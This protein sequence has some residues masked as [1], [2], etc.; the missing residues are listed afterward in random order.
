M[1]CFFQEFTQND[2]SEG[3]VTVIRTHDKKCGVFSWNAVNLL[4]CAVQLQ[5]LWTRADPRSRC[6]CQRKLRWFE[7]GLDGAV[8]LCKCW[9]SWQELSSLPESQLKIIH[10]PTPTW[11]FLPHFSL[12]FFICMWRSLSMEKLKWLDYFRIWAWTV[13]LCYYL[14]SRTLSPSTFLTQPGLL[15]WLPLLSCCEPGNSECFVWNLGLHF[16]LCPALQVLWGWCLGGIS[17][18]WVWALCAWGG[19]WVTGGG[20][21]SCLAGGCCHS[22]NNDPATEPFIPS[23]LVLFSQVKSL[24]RSCC[25]CGQE[26]ARK[27]VW[28][29]HHSLIGSKPKEKLK[30]S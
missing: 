21:S 29:A 19:Q 13:G 2:I 30:V 11:V 12:I 18:C 25:R 8:L 20:L 28:K 27:C 4:K 16:Q 15:S 24:A 23:V 1:G 22:D 10:F 3:H 26:G 7:W 6:S 17:W 9:F 14:P 5:Q